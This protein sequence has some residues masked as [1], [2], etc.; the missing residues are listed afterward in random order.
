MLIVNGLEL[1]QSFNLKFQN[2][3]FLFTKSY[4]SAYGYIGTCRTKVRIKNLAR[5]N[6]T[7]LTKII[8]MEYKAEPNQNLPSNSRIYLEVSNVIGHPTLHVH[9]GFTY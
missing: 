5:Y 9:G 6:C 7:F 3:P 4:T 8:K 2:N 1:S